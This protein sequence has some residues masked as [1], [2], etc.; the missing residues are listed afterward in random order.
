ML[1]RWLTAEINKFIHV[2][3]RSCLQAR[4]LGDLLLCQLKRS[5]VLCDT[6]SG[7]WMKLR[8]EEPPHFS[9]ELLAFEASLLALWD[10]R[11][12]ISMKHFT[13]QK[14]RYSVSIA[15]KILL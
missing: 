6:R 12:Q 1:R 7:E 4:A 5:L 10:I 15:R 8:K 3:F 9:S 14:G 13:T 11:I 2:R